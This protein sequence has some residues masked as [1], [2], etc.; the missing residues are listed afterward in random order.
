MLCSVCKTNGTCQQS[1]L[2]IDE[3][4]SG[5][6]IYGFTYGNMQNAVTSNGTEIIPYLAGEDRF[7]TIAMF[8]QG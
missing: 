3:A 5:I 1:P 8:K 7:N 6:T 2:S 4:S